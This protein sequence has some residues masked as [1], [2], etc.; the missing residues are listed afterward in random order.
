MA[1]SSQTERRDPGLSVFI[2]HFVLLKASALLLCFSTTV[3]I[4]YKWGFF[5]H[6][7][8]SNKAFSILVKCTFAK[9]WQLLDT[10][11]KVGDNK[12]WVKREFGLFPMNKRQNNTR[13]NQIL[14]ENISFN[15]IQSV[16]MV[17]FA[18]YTGLLKLSSEKLWNYTERCHCCTRGASQNVPHFR[19]SG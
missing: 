12:S 9:H 14:S 10:K 13:Y 11:A 2:T 4:S 8:K 7:G 3:R 16:F 17:M 19:S 18:Q 5:L 1:D 6:V 15:W